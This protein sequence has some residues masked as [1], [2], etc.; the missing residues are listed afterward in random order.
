MTE[1]RQIAM[2]S[3]LLPL[4]EV[5]PVMYGLIQEEAERQRDSIDLIASENYASVSVMQAMGSVFT[6]KYAEG[7]P[8]RRYYGGCDVVDKVESLCIQRALEA[9]NL[10]PND[11]GVNVQPLSGTPANMAVYMG[12]LSPHDKIMGLRL[13]SGGH[14]THGYHVGQ[15]KISA[16]S[17]YYSSL[18]Y[19]VDKET[20]FLDYDKMEELAKAF[21]PK[22]IIAGASCY[23]RYWDYKRCREIADK[24]GAYLM[25]DIAHIS[26][27]VA[28]GLHPSPFEHCHVVTSTT[29]KTLKGPRSGIIFYSKRPDETIETKINGAVFPCMQGGP[30]TNAIAALAVQLKV[31]SSPEWKVYAQRIVDNAR[32]LAAE[33]EKRGF[34]VVTGGT[35]NHT[36]LLNLKPLCVNGSKVEHV[37]NSANITINK[38]TVPGDVSA[39]NPSGVRLGTA[40]VTSR[41]AC[42]ADME[43]IADGLLEVVGICKDIIEKSGLKIEDFKKE[44]SNHPGIPALREKV[45]Q[46]MKKFPMIR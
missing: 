30:H 5:D 3:D 39:M 12:L 20:G 11:W 9:F 46:W 31:V 45:A 16:S 13:S 36:V 4:K 32:A 19:D 42:P 34:L 18:L 38:S 41:G 35:D 17:V 2:P 14:L 28:A 1:E 43:F 21:C 24:V 8:G 10:D 6:N 44:A 22:L 40:A 23:T 37:A 15:K 26:G 25:A 27:L 33:C 7:Y 29:H